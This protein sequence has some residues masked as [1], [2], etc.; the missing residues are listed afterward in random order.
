MP[1]P[2]ILTAFSTESALEAIECLGYPAVLKPVVGSWGRLLAKVNDRDAAEAI[3]EHKEVLYEE[4][5]RVPFIVSYKGVTKAGAVDR[6]HLVSNGLDLT[7][8]LCDFA[9]IK[10]PASLHGRSVRP[11]AVG[12]TPRR[13]RDCVV[14]ENHLARLVHGGDWKYLV[15]RKAKHADDACGIC[16]GELRVFAK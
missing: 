14:V 3:L 5:I 11:L 4:A 2:R 1:Q 12:E 15:G 6:E 13:W 9:G 10:T 8:T 16:Q 7:P